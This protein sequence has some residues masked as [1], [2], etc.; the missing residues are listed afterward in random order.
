M[1]QLNFRFRAVTAFR[2][3]ASSS[4]YRNYA[5]ILP[6]KIDTMRIVLI[7]LQSST[8]TSDPEVDTFFRAELQSRPSRTEDRSRSGRQG[9][10][11]FGD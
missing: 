3:I 1:R 7:S 5:D 9:S 8:D 10:A 11:N 6:L 4:V 2:K